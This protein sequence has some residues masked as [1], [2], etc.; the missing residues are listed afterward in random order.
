ML[1]VKSVQENLREGP[2]GVP[3]MPAMHNCQLDLCEAYNAATL[4]LL[5][6][7]VCPITNVCLLFSL[8]LTQ[9]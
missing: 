9:A 6:N 2:Y 4:R 8:S 1:L 3:A 5:C 7:L